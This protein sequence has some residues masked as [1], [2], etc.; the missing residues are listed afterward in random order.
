MIRRR[1]APQEESS[2][3]DDID[4]F[5]KL[6]KEQPIPGAARSS[7]APSND[8]SHE[9][10]SLPVVS[11]MT[12]SMKRH[13]VALSNTRKKQMDALIQELE[14][15]KSAVRREPRGLVPD[16]RGSY[17]EP[18]DEHRT[19]N[20][21]VGNLA[22]TL[23]EEAIIE[24][25]ARFGDLLSLKV[26]W[27]RTVEERE[28]N[29][30]SCFVCYRYRRDAEAAMHACSESDPF[31][32][33]RRLMVRWGKNMLPDT[34]EP[35][36]KR[37]RHD[38]LDDEQPQDGVS[39]QLNLNTAS[40]S[41]RA[42]HRRR[43]RPIDGSGALDPA[44]LEEFNKLTRRELSASRQSICVAMAFCFKHSSSS[45]QISELLKDLLLDDH[46][47]VETRVARL[48]LLSDVLFN[49]QQPGIK[50]A[51]RYRDA[52]E[53][54]TP[55]VF[56]SLGQHGDA[57]LS[58][59]T[60]HKIQMSVRAVLAAWTN[61]S[62]FDPAF[63]DELEACF[64]GREISQPV[65][66]EEEVIEE[67]KHDK[68]EKDENELIILSARG[69]WTDVNENDDT[70][71]PQAHPNKSG[72]DGEPKN[73]SNEHSVRLTENNSLEDDLDG[74]PLEEGDLDEEGLRRLNAIHQVTDDDDDDSVGNDSVKA[75][76]VHSDIDGESLV[77][78][79]ELEDPGH[80]SQYGI[81][82]TPG[83]AESG[84]HGIE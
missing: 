77:D 10:P 84:R 66:V 5:A 42:E 45:T 51:F 37:Q 24:V 79:E 48:F 12:S 7:T 57:S 39:T 23:T 28:R 41:G 18:E 50:N 61:W 20:L 25:F 1:A 75:M 16:K 69:D 78:N 6:P 3:E 47:S 43:G 27:P 73:T 53:K 38:P 62:V 9:H 32:V 8:D 60:R 76:M 65:P 52:I 58:R 34:S 67:S 15:E 36:V 59:M 74:E 22:P 40:R 70:E 19:T 83:S 63:L 17:V 14:T 4:M 71:Q 49:S 72:P 26:M 21:F 11:S 33:G 30:V 56:A 2:D 80:S 44:A 54:M 68:V 82:Q 31:F 13:H 81:A 29:R 55:A 46:C 35:V 64:E